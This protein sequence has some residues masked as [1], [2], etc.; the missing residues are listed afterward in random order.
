[1]LI[2]F[3]IAIVR[4]VNIIGIFFLASVKTV[5]LFTYLRESGYEAARLKSRLTRNMTAVMHKLSS[6]RYVLG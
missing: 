2:I 5:H 1:M 4:V 3:S 6:T